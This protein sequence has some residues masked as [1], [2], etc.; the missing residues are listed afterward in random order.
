MDEGKVIYYL[1]I[2][3]D[4][5]KSSI[6]GKLGYPSSASSF[7]TSSLNSFDDLSNEADFSAAQIVD[8]CI[9]DLNAI[10]RTSINVRW[11]GEKTL[12]NPIMIDVHYGVAIS[13]LAKRLQEKGLY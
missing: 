5:M 6:R 4:W 3:R 12:V 10:E 9:D 8:A 2:W 1:E 7:A 11:L 13:K